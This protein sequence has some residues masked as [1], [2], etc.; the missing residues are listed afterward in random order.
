MNAMLRAATAFSV[1]LALCPGA[2]AACELETSRTATVAQVIDG[3]TVRLDDASEVRLIGALAPQTPRW[4]K[5]DAAWPPA[6]R[7]RRVLE[8]L[9]GSSKVELRFAPREEQWEAYQDYHNRTSRHPLQNRRCQ[10]PCNLCT[11]LSAR[12]P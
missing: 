4:W 5:K 2:V 10:E 8:K 9:I 1:F 6:L 3:Q 12:N 7:A 11:D